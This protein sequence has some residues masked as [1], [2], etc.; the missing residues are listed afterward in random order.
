[1]K[2]MVILILIFIFTGVIIAQEKTLKGI[3]YSSS[4]GS[5]LSDANVVVL[6]SNAGTAT[7]KAGA[8]SLNYNF[9]SD[10]VIEISYIG[11][12]KKRIN[13]SDLNFDKVNK[14]YLISKIITSQT[15]LVSGSIGEEGK[16][17]ITFAKIKK[18]DIEET[19]TVQD[20]PKY[21]SSL[22]STTFYSEN[23][24]GLGYNYISIRGFGQR[25]IS[26][27][28][29]GIPQNEPEDHNVYWLDFPDILESTELIQV[30]RGAGSGV[31]GYPAIGGSI[32]IITSAFSDKP[33]ME[34]SSSIGSYNTRKY[35][36][37]F[38]SGLI[39]N[40][41]SVYVKLS[42]IL[43]SGYRNMSWVNFHSFH[44]SA[45]RYD[46]NLTTQINIYGGPVADGLAYNGLPKFAIKDKN[47]RRQN[48]SYFEASDNQI[49]YATERRPDEIENFSQPHFE[50]LNEY[51]VNDNIKL[52]SALFLIL[53]DGFFDYDGSWADTS[54]FRLT[55]ANGFN[56]TSNPENVLIRA[57]VDNKQWGWIPRVS[58]A[59]TN[60]ELILGGELRIHRSIHWG[61]LNYGWNLPVGL[62]KDYRYY[63]YEGGNDI[64]G[65]YAHESYDLNANT[66]ILAE[67]QLAYHKYRIAN[68]RYVHNDFTISNLFINPRFGI[69]YKFTPALNVYGAF[70][71]VSRAPRL[72]DYYD[73][74]ESS[75]GAEPQF[76]L[77]SSGNYDFNNPFVKP[78]TMNDIEIGAG[79]NKEKLSLNMNLFY[80]LFDHEIVN[81]G[82]VDRFGQPITGN[83][84]KT[85]HNGI[86][87]SA[88]YAANDNFEIIL[89]G[90][91]SKNYV[92]RGINYVDYTDPNTG[93]AKVA[94]VDLSDN[95]IGGFPDVIFNGVIKYK[96]SGFF[97]QLNAQ[98]VGD[99][100]SDNYDN[101][102]AE[103]RSLYPGITDYSDNKVESYFTAD[104]MTSYE[105]SF[106]PAFN[107]IKVFLQVN[108]LFDNL[109]AAYAIG[110]EF[111]PMAERNF[112][113]GINV[114][115]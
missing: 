12:N 85:I 9:H 56:V 58:I 23:G 89:N 18:A 97:A 78:E 46:E 114:G 90:T 14:I 8:F 6:N 96:N 67:V 72:K 98:Y 3:V 33:K 93:D 64:A 55:Q 68:E 7:D 103:Y 40:K 81:Q 101:K 104:F 84:D 71:R 63:Y 11:Y 91:Y 19:Y 73:A 50:L 51:K 59:H 49:T 86:E 92:S 95:R 30:Q 16:T 13:V 32:N 48:Y 53:G 31:V 27:S 22:P 113:A 47:L 108:N 43:S 4:D 99:F 29:N 69:N 87:L 100:Y 76:A 26:I 25:R 52:N 65:F 45:A 75:G 66:N 110:K 41:Y 107:K 54:Y 38:A 105:F 36:A 88:T 70:A 17:P 80:M 79:L 42:N 74:A 39:D 57:Q 1:M 28:V 35:S 15:I 61:S 24:N 94:P 106:A 5:I 115:L 20:I 60:G 21:L 44:I 77:D 34:L 83:I 82:R 10:D 102:L 2:N 112:L 111:F 62:T 37:S 109:Y